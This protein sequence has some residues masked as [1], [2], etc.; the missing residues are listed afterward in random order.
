MKEQPLE[1]EIR[2]PAEKALLHKKTMN[3]SFRNSKKLTLFYSI[4]NSDT[5]FLKGT[6]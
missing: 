6:S 2:T 3:M 1:K 5:S 4:G